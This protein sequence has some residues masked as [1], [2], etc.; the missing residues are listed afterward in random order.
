MKTRCALLLI[1]LTDKPKIPNDLIETEAH[2]SRLKMDKSDLCY[3]NYESDDDD[4]DHDDHDDDGKREIWRA[5]CV[6][7]LESIGVVNLK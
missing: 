5:C 3:D 4:D 2:K 1:K 7:K 6:A